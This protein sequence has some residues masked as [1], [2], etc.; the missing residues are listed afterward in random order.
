MNKVIL[1]GR[2]TADPQLQYTQSGRKHSR[3]TVAVNNPYKDK[4]G[5]WQEDTAFVD[6]ILWGEKAERFIER[7][8]KGARVLVEGRLIQ[9]RWEDKDGNKRSKLEVRIERVQVLDRRSEEPE[10]VDDIEF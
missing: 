5:D 7:G 8:Y 6:C 1:L 9:N 2:L 10:E 3:F 4:N